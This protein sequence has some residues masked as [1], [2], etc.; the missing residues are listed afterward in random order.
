MNKPLVAANWK[1]NKGPKEAEE[2]FKSFKQ[3]I[4]QKW[5]DN[6]LFF[7]PAANWFVA[8]K[9]LDS[10]F[11]WGAQNIYKEASGAFT[12]EN[13][14][15]T[16]KE[17]GGDHVLVGHSE[18]RQ[19][20]NEDNKLLNEKVLFTISQNLVPVLCVGET[21][22]QREAG[23]TM[24]VVGEQ[25]EK[26]LDSVKA[27]DNFIIAY[28]PVWAI[29]TGVVA[30]PEQA[31]E[32]HAFVR[33]KMGELFSQNKAEQTL[34]LYGGSVKA[35]NAKEL[36]DRPDIDGFLVGGASLDPVQFSSIL[37]VCLK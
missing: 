1:L 2:F 3:G 37:E 15:A 12:G 13:S 7:I 14:A 33:K 9:E 6:F 35:S 19:I 27:T 23:Q 31:Q 4:G 25:L 5:K 30:S 8:Q 11:S 34:I 18:R 24:Q 10:Q 32:V 16:L 26:G 36:N 21:L 28:E 17:F 29:G 22:E 20:F